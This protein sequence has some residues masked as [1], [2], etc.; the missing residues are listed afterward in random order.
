MT[1]FWILVAGLAGVPGSTDGTGAAARFRGINRGMVFDAAGNLYVAEN[2]NHT[3][4][5]IAPDGQASSHSPH[6]A[7]RSW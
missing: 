6:T 7:Q 1:I 4:R 3:I 5:R 2:Q